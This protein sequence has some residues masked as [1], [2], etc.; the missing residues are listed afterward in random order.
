MNPPATLGPYLLERKL[1]QGGMSVVYLARAFGASGFEKQVVLK[2]L[3]EELAQDARAQRM[4]LEEARLQALARH[5]NL[6]QAHDL[7]VQDGVYFARLDW[8]DGVTLAQLLAGGPVPEAPAL[9]IAAEL[10]LGLHA[11]HET[12]DLDG[13]PLGLVHRDL[14]PGNVLLSRLG[15]VKLADFGIAKATLRKESTHAGLLKGT[16][17]YMSPE[18][19]RGQPLTPASDTFSLGTLLA[20]VLTGRRLFEGEHPMDTLERVRAAELPPLGLAPDVDGLLRACLHA[21][22][23]SALELHRRLLDLL[24]TRPGF[25]AAHLGALVEARPQT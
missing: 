17:A 20:E 12:R 3:R 19:T 22:L 10:A 11:L 14:S 21:R 25:D 13:R 2:T 15:E 9:F 8:V 24:R 1:G 18:Q 7:G 6:V 16:F 4:F 23:D 5:R